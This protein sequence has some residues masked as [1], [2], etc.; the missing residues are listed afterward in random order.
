MLRYISIS[1]QS[2]SLNQRE[3]YYLNDEN[4]SKLIE[5]I[6][7]DLPD[8][9][10]LIVLSTCNRTEVYFESSVT[11][12]IDFCHYFI[13]K[14]NPQKDVIK[15]AR[16]FFMSDCPAITINYLLRVA[17]GLQSAVI[18]DGQILS[19]LKEA[20]QFSLQN[21]MQGSVTE[22]A[23]QAVFRSH[24]RVVTQT[25]FKRGSKSTAYRALKIVEENF[26]KT[27]L[28]HKKLLIVGA[29]QIAVEILKYL[30][31]FQFSEVYLS[32][33]TEAK[34]QNLARIYGTSVLPWQN[35]ENNE[36]EAFDAVI[37]AVSNQKDLLK[38]GIPAHNKMVMVDLALPRNISRSLGE[39][40]NVE[41]YNIDLV[42]DQIE[43]ADAKRNE[44]IAEVEALIQQ[45]IDI[46]TD[47]LKNEGV[48]KLLSEYKLNINTLINEAVQA[49]VADK[50]TLDETKKLTD[51]LAKKI[52]R[53]PAVTMHQM[54][55]NLFT[56]D[57]I[58]IA[59]NVLQ[60]TV[61]QKEM[62][63]NP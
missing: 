13:L 2:G 31:K 4:R 50:L 41:L 23:F 11:R 49:T 56:K 60:G 54:P 19:Q 42:A 48:R 29:G 9:K 5:A 35:I 26:G 55:D 57:Q 52:M 15:E 14:T 12:A 33:R 17:N 3:C 44:S 45:E 58:T 7:V 6:K 20:Y 27:V 36:Y 30:S 10:G 32:N 22:R 34:A 61:L 59:R 25:S 28:V 38:S 62:P 63:D 47:W 51:M 1:H 8:I 37:T 16:L 21:K 39:N 40:T 46:F 18:G 53:S 43:K 24:K